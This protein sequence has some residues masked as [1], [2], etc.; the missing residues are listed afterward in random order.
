MIINDYSIEL[1]PINFRNLE[2]NAILERVHQTNDN[3]LHTFK[4][5]NVVLDDENPL[6][7]LTVHT[8]ALYTPDQLIFVPN[9]IIN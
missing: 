8:T 1:K 4:V 7:G 9:S 5:Q 6:D 2:A 3:I